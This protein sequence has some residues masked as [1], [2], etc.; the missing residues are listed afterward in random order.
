MK[1]TTV[2][3]VV[4]AAFLMT[5]C[6]G[7]KKSDDV[8]TQRVTK[9]EP[10]AP[11]RMQEN[12]DERDVEWIGKTY[13]VTIQ[14]Q[15]CDSLPMVKDDMGQEYV[16]NVFSVVVSRQDGSVFYRHKFQKSSFA[17]HVSDDFRKT[18]ILEGLVL[19]RAEDDYLIFAAS[20]G[21]PQTDEYIPLV[22]KLSRMGS[23]EIRQDT[24]LDTSANV[25][26]GGANSDDD[27]V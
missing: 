12:T 16:D 2:A 27:G 11:V 6:G 15:P 7:K 19:D 9:A 18:G 4:C 20:V 14:R 26:K 10:K 3:L 13:H 17:N 25:E 21:R 5:A 1:R 23:L 22:V 8:I 24:E